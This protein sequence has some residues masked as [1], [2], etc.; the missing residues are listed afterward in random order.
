MNQSH[1]FLNTSGSFVDYFDDLG[2]TESADTP[3]LRRAKGKMA[4]LYHPDT[5]QAR[6]R[7]G[8]ARKADI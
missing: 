4:K 7:D 1:S 5:Q 2:E 3:R 6:V 8:T